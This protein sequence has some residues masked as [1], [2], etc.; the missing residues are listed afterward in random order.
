MPGTIPE[1]FV[2]P[3]GED[4]TG[5]DPQD[6]PRAEV[7]YYSAG[8]DVPLTASV[9]RQLATFAGTPDLDGN[10]ANDDGDITDDVD[11]PAT[12]WG[13]RVMAVNRVVERNVA[14]DTISTDTDTVTLADDDGIW[15]TMIR[16]NNAAGLDNAL[17]KPKLEADRH[18]PSDRGR[19]GI[20]L[21]WEVDDPLSAADREIVGAIQYRVEYSEDRIDW[22]ALPN[23][24]ADADDVFAAPVA[25]T[26]NRPQA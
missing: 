4:L 1:A 25:Q 2:Q 11:S 9:L 17:P 10:D 16:V 14:D 18:T 19:T 6:P 7:Y 13:F 26:A 24:G 21:E 15:S 20:E 23:E 8:T 12:Q 5:T 22:T 3:N